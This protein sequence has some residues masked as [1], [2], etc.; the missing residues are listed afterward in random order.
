M[1]LDHW[2]KWVEKQ[3]K[4]T[5]G[6]VAVWLAIVNLVAFIW[7]LGGTGLVDETEP[8][9]AEASRQMLVTGDWV[10][11]YW[12]GETRFDKPALVYWF[13]AICYKL[14]GVNEWGARLPSALSAIALVYFGYY[15][16]SYFGF[17]SPQAVTESNQSRS[18]QAQRQLLLSAIIGATFMAINPQTISWARVGVSDMLLSACIGGALF[19]FFIAYGSKDLPEMTPPRFSAEFWY[20]AFY[21]FMGLAVLT[22][23]PIGLVLPGL[24]VLAFTLY[25][26]NCWQ[27]FWE[28][29]PIRG[30]GL[31]AAINAPW[32]IL[33]TLAN[34]QKYIDSF[35]GYHNVERFTAVV[36]RH[37]A[38]IYFYL[39]VILVGFF[40]ASVYLPQAIA[41]IRVQQR[42]RWQEAPRCSQLGLFALFWFATVFIF[43][44]IAVT[45]LP[46]YVLPLM[47]AAAILVAL[48]WSN[49]ER[50]Y[51]L[52]K[53]VLLG[54]TV[55]NIGVYLAIAAVSYWGTYW[56]GFDPMAPQLPQAIRDT[57]LPVISAVF[58]LG[59]AGVLGWCLWQH[60]ERW[61]W[62]VNGVAMV[63][64]I[65]II[66]TPAAL[67]YDQQRQAPL[68]ELSAIAQVQAQP[69][70]E[71][72]MIGDTKP[73]VV[74]YAQKPVVY[75]WAAQ[76]LLPHLSG[77][78]RIE[79]GRT[80][81]M[82]LAMRDQLQKTGLKARNWE[83]LGR[84]GSY[85]LVRVTIE[86]MQN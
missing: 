25:L 81:A 86:T 60:Q 8:L 31:V 6:L 76:Q 7:Y 26:G 62:V 24:T 80:S 57:G 17:P 67:V 39:I 21:G 36:N 10:T 85:R 47:P 51:P 23:G 66:M 72:I 22:K 46:S 20:L 53:R 35:F 30:L 64:A 14:V 50:D 83:V 58:W 68:R 71:L 32:Y 5:G 11:P 65:F 19:S 9:F 54:S 18:S 59:C 33:V 56:I 37:S 61:V 34:G 40:P 74:F 12:N 84:S 44:T 70:E 42:S 3:P 49:Q 82:I 41:R 29:K 13:M 38:P 52:T 48:L 27:V 79:L 63:L 28:S 77:T 43:F 55:A 16:L 4:V 78:M 15:T 2:W 73:S 1:G 69:Q 75:L 45:K